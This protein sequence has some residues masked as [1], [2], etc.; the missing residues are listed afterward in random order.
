MFRA[1]PRFRRRVSDSFRRTFVRA[2]LVGSA[3]VVGASTLGCG[4]SGNR[5]VVDESGDLAVGGGASGVGGEMGGRVVEMPTG[6]DGTQWR[7]TQASCTEGPLDLASRG[8]S[9]HLTIEQPEEQDLLLLTYDMTFANE[10]CVV[11][12]LQEVT[13]PP[14]PGELRI[15]EVARV[16]VPHT[17]ECFGQPEP[18]RPGEVR[19]NGRNLEVL[20]QRSRWC[21]GY[22]VAMTFEPALPRLWTNEDLARR[23]VAHFTRGDA[24][25]LAALFS[26][27]GAV[28]ESFTMTPTGDPYRHEG[29]E[30]VREYF[31][32]S[33][34]GAPW[35]AM[36]IVGFEPGPTP[37]QT[38][39][40]WEYMDPRL[41]EPVAGHNVFTVAAGEIFEAQIVL[42]GPPRLAGAAAR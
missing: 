30:A 6:L 32:Q 34:S 25:R 9:A 3:T 15:E 14:S 20:V 7:W 22:E 26:S 1:V 38:R 11:T 2:W 29:R 21:N 39:M 23:Y 5:R 27:V 10:G 4:G 24:T 35:R 17:P 16:A 31:H 8:F 33:F 19:R 40:R 12:V 18:P 37:Q 41:A 28:L 36:R 42:D 13:P